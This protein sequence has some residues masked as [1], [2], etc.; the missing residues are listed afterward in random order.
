[1]HAADYIALFDTLSPA[2]K[3]Q[4]ASHFAACG[5]RLENRVRY[6]SGAEAKTAARDVF[7]RHE[8]LFRRLAEA[9]RDGMDDAHSGV[10]G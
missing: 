6:A 4:V 10:R 5:L 8:S 7:R 3:A 9:E 2:D 1:M